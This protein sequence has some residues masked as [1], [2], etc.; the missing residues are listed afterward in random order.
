MKTEY[1]IYAIMLGGFV[2]AMVCCG[3]AKYLERIDRASRRVGP[4]DKA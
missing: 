1:V 4:G 3:I 2:F